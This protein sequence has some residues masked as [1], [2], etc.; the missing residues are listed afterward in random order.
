MKIK[1]YNRKNQNRMDTNQNILDNQNYL[2][3]IFKNISY[4]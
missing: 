4:F 3:D 2:K 1:F